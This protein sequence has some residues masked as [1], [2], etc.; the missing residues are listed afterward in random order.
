MF[1]PILAVALAAPPPSIE[2]PVL[3]G[4]RLKRDAAVLFG[5]EDYTVFPDALG[6]KADATA[7]RDFLVSTRG[8]DASRVIRVDDATAADAR[9]ALARAAKSVKRGGMLWVFW[10]G[11]GALVDDQRVLLGADAAADTLAETSLGLT[12]LVAACEASKAAR[13]LVI[14]DA[15]FGGRGRV[16]EPMLDPPDTVSPLATRAGSNVS[17]W[18]ATT[19]GDTAWWYP[20]AGHGMFSY[21]AIGALRGW[22]DGQVGAP[23]DNGVNLQE[24][25]GYVARVI[26]AVGGGEQKPTKETRAEPAAWV[27]SKGA[28][29]ASPSKEALAALALAEKA[30]RVRKAEAALRIVATQDWQGLAEKTATATPGNIEALQAFL[31]RWDTASVSVDGVEVAV[32]IPEVAAARARLDD[33]ARAADKA[34]KKKKR[35][36][37]TS[38]RVVLPPPIVATGPCAD[39][40]VLEPKA[41][42][43]ELTTELTQCLEARLTEEKLQT[44]RDKLSRL[45]L[46]N[47]DARGDMPA[48]IQL[49]ARHLEE[50]DRS[51]PDFCFK[52]ALVLSRGGI[53]DAEIVLRWSGYALENK[54]Q[55]EGATYV[56]RVYN[57]LRLRAETS[58]R[59]WHDAEADFIEERSEENAGN[60]ERYRGQAKD[61][62]RE[63]VDYAR[64]SAQPHDRAMTLCESA[65]GN[66]AFCAA[67]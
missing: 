66:T 19:T 39:L 58:T 7:M 62:A 46:V 61:F 56:S 63:W 45:L 44:T 51:D 5:I 60:A 32:A 26:R 13:A 49:A 24:A 36:K 53:E 17:V 23:A 67:G 33:F 48:W 2:A 14:V 9:E 31:K 34:N 50:I 64:S 41:I 21:F 12:E 37:R 4:E 65:A 28:L 35:K 29:E 47:A 52:F 3:T 8:I 38:A 30:R 18:T 10:S 20:D 11:H 59:L 54:H 22:A 55:W 40:V 57:L 1:L 43:G 15:G 27:L 25:Q 42:T 6:A 16:G